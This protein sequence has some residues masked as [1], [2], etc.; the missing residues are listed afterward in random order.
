MPVFKTMRTQ[1]RELGSFHLSYASFL[2]YGMEVLSASPVLPD[3]EDDRRD[4]WKCL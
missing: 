4:T 3:I 2:Q 1:R